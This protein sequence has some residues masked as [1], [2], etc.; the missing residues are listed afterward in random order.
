MLGTETYNWPVAG[1]YAMLLLGSALYEVNICAALVP[2]EGVVTVT[3]QFPS[4][5]TL[6][7]GTVAC[8]TVVL[9]KVVGTATPLKET[10]EFEAKFAPTTCSV[11]AVLIGPDFG[12]MELNVGAAAKRGAHA[13]KHR[14]SARQS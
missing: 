8:R 2:A 1:L 12:E 13:S 11:T 4:V 6:A 5:A 3:A 7:A 14:T 10:C 9:L